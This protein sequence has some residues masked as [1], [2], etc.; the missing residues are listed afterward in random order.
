M[1]FA[2]NFSDLIP[3]RATGRMAFSAELLGDFQAS[4][5]GVAGKSIPSRAG[6]TDGAG[7]LALAVGRKNY[8]FSGSDAGGQRA[9]HICT[10][11]RTA[12]LNGL[13][14]ETCLRDVLSRIGEHPINRVDEL[15]PWAWATR[16]GGG[17]L[18][19]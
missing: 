4:V 1:R 15:L 14:P 18:A 10:L 2:L 9:A 3:Y 7:E 6:I 12:K 16:V 5:R 11:I 13:E 8:L 17:K 19:A